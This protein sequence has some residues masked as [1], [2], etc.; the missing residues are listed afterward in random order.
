MRA[1]FFLCLFLSV[2]TAKLTSESD[3]KFKIAFGSC[4]KQT[5]PLPIFYEV[6]KQNP[7]VFIFLG[8]NIYGDTHDM[9]VLKN[10]PLIRGK[11]ILS[12]LDSKHR[13]T[14]NLG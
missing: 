2:F 4:G 14:G 10:I 3:S 9:D 5:H 13:G 1:Q 11:G 7:N 8:D 6:V 12:A